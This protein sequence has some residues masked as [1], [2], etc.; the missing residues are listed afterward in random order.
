MA[1]EQ[2]IE[3]RANRLGGIAGQDWYHL[4]IVYKDGAGNECFLRGGPQRGG[5]PEAGGMLSEIS[6]G[7]VNSSSVGSS[8]SSASGLTEGSGSNP[9]SAS[10]KQAGG[11]FGNICTEVRWL[12]TEGVKRIV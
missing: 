2:T 7:A 3:V 9:S 12:D 10:D 1:T 11:P 8:R 5:P 4:Y 6:G